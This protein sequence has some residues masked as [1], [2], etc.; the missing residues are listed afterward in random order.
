M[1]SGNKIWKF[2]ELTGN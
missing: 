2:T 1:F